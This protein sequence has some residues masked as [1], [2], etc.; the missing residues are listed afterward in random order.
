MAR[1][2]TKTVDTIFDI[3]NVYFLTTHKYNYVIN[4]MR[5][6][7]RRIGKDELKQRQEISS[8]FFFILLCFLKVCLKGQI[9]IG[10]IEPMRS[11]QTE[12]SK[13]WQLIDITLMTNTR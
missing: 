4:Y 6:I 13:K 9:K 5:A 8:G 10:S 11:Q 3:G 1:H 7:R 2:E 12:W